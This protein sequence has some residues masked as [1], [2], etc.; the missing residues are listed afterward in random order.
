[1]T[2][3]EIIKEINEN[4]KKMATLPVTEEAAVATADLAGSDTTPAA[5]ENWRTQRQTVRP[6]LPAEESRAEMAVGQDLWT[7][8]SLDH[9][10]PPPSSLLLPYLRLFLKEAESCTLAPSSWTPQGGSC[11]QLTTMNYFEQFYHRL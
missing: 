9:F 8:T 1:M 7:P 11:R 10:P 3:K 5:T 2:F 4:I 6:T